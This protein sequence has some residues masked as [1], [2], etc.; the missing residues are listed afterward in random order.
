MY[1]HPNF[2]SM[3]IR[4]SDGAFVP[5]DNP[6][7]LAWV[8]KGN[9]IAPADVVP[10]SQEQLDIEAAKIYAK[11][12]ALRTMTPQQVQVWVDANVNNLADAKDALK[13]LAIAVG[14]LA[15]RL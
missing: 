12:A 7:L 8:A 2:G 14:V 11:L 3:V 6:D 5:R 13:T 9:V 10:V 1:K 15:R 4:L